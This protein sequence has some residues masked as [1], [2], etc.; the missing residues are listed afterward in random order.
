MCVRTCACS[1]LDIPASERSTS[2]ALIRYRHYEKM[3]TDINIHP[4]QFNQMYLN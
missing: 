4:K 3:N 2:I 1:Y